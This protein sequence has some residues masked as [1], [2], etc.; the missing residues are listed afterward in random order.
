[1]KRFKKI[2]IEIS[3]VCNLQCSFCPVV[4]RDDQ[5]MGPELF[6]QII[7]DAAPMTDEVCFHL[8]G[9]PLNHP[10]FSEYLEICQSHNLPVNLTT[11]G[12]LLNEIRSQACLHPIIRQINI[13][14]HSFEANFPNGDVH[15][16]LEKVFAFAKRALLE[17]PD[18]YVNLRLWNL[19]SAQEA[20]P[21]KTNTIVLKEIRE[22]FNPDFQS[23][24]DIRRKKGCN[25]KGRLYL[26]Y[27]SQ[28][29]WPHPSQPVR[30]DQG[31]CHGLS[32]HIG[33]LADGTVVPCCLDK[34]GVITLGSCGAQRLDEILKGPRAMKIGSGFAQGVL[35]EDLCQK[36][37][38]ISRFDK[39]ARRLKS[40]L[41][42]QSSSQ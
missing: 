3:N 41:M 12:T 5:F 35:V 27:D 23:T 19:P 10:R 6:R 18:L 7:K 36:C 4:E 20:S 29:T 25:V 17:R 37:T 30:G 42:N 8:M 21:S 16:Y 14:V 33:I 32:S 26:N 38:F 15:T 34:E 2:Y 9:E 28:F 39:K 22:H 11:N 1:M 40:G 24:T 31:F 13:S